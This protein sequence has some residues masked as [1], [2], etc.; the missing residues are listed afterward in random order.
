LLFGRRRGRNQG[1]RRGRSKGRALL[2][3]AVQGSAA[4]LVDNLLFLE[5]L[6]SVVFGVHLEKFALII[7]L[8]P[9]YHVYVIEMVFIV[10]TVV[11]HV[12]VLAFLSHLIKKIL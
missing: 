3:F 9:E 7:F 11:D 12:Q 6:F 2:V 1:R 5:H 8:V 4:A 10:S